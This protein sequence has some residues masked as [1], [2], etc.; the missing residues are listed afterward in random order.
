MQ[1]ISFTKLFRPLLRCGFWQNIG[2]LM[3]LLASTLLRVYAAKYKLMNETVKLK[4]VT[5]RIVL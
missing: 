4:T 3:D 1:N 5:T 2:G